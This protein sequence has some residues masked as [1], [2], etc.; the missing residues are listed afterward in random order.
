MS[1]ETLELKHIR[2]IPYYLNGTI[3]NTF[4]ISRGK[5]VAEKC[6][7]I[8]T[9]DA[10]SDS[11]TYYSDWRERVQPNLDIFRNE[12]VSKEREKLRQDFVKPQKPRKAPRNPR[13]TS[14]RTK[15][16]KSK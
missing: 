2:G 15:S 12:L 1:T 4:E 9:Y 7:A 10:T 11:I 13:K 8:G 3:V 16:T 5:P 6:V 14:S